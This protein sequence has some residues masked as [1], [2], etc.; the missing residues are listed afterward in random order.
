MKD[1]SSIC[2][3]LKTLRKNG[4][5]VAI[6]D[7]GTGYSSLGYLQHLPLDILK[8]DRTFVNNMNI[9]K[10]ETSLIAVIVRMAKGLGLTTVVEGVE[11]NDQAGATTL[12]GCDHAQGWLF[13]KAMPACDLENLVAQT[14]RKTTHCRDR[15]A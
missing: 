4:I 1:M 10:A 15:A 13:A 3:H 9:D 6:D 8:I 12:I 2:T 7:F 5:C 11:T 14:A